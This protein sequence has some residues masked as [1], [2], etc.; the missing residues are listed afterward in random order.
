[1]RRTK[2]YVAHDENNVC[3][4][5]E[6]VRIRECRPLGEGEY[7]HHDL[8]GLPCVSTDGAVLGHVV[9]VENFGAGDIIEIEKPPELGKQSKRFMVPMNADAVPEW[10]ADGIV[11][12]A[13][14]VA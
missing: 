14:F 12:D 6:I 3:K 2:R 13:A 1:M 10:N 7:Y 5:G 11:V 9:A 4:S 8:I